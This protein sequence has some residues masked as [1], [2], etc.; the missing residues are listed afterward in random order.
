MEVKSKTKASK[1][2]MLKFYKV[3]FL[4]CQYDQ[5]ELHNQIRHDILK[6][7]CQTPCN[8]NG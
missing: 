4:V 7:L 6:E 5:V 3:E 8:K 2:N 1:K